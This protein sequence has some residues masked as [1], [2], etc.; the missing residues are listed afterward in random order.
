MKRDMAANLEEGP[1]TIRQQIIDCLIRQD[2]SAGDLSRAVGVREKEVALHLNHI[3][4]SAAA[5]GKTLVIRPFECL[6][7]GYE[8]KDRKRYTRP[9]RCPKCKSTHVETPTFRIL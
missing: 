1:K 5:K 9:G 7:C 8:F 4:R 3:G 2:M 6:S